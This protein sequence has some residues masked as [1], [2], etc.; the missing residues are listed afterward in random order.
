MRGQ[1][2]D[3]LIKQRYKR[4]RFRFL[5]RLS[6]DLQQPGVT[7]TG[8][9]RQG[10]RETLDPTD[11]EGARLDIEKNIIAK[12][13]RCWDSVSVVLPQT[14]TETGGVKQGLRHARE[15]REPRTRA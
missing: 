2:S 4:R 3:H 9:N 7:V 8:R 13:G 10:T 5:A 15:I 1:S 14:L 6:A 12:S 11:I